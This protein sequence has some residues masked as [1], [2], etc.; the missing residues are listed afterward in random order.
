V[1]HI[2]NKSVFTQV[3]ANYSKGLT[4]IWNELAV[5]VTFESDWAKAKGMLETLAV[6][7][8]AQRG[9]A[10]KGKLKDAANRYYINYDNLTPIV[11]TR[12]MDSGVRLTVRYLVEPRQRRN[13]ENAMWEDILRTFAKEPTIEFAY[14]TSRRFF[15]DVEGPPELRPNKMYGQPQDNQESD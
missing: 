7:H 3:L 1:L 10:A 15:H 9:Q 2:P 6:E 12:V 13:T 8:A 5:L 11:Y 14:P 4:Y